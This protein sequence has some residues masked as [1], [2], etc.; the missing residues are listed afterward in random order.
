MIFSKQMA[1][2]VA[3]EDIVGTIASYPNRG[4]NIKKEVRDR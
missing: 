2:T 1:I 3:P 4:S